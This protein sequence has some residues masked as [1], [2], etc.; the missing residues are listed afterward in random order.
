M[1]HDPMDHHAFL[2]YLLRM[3]LYLLR[4]SLAYAIL[5]SSIYRI[6]SPSL[7][8]QLAVS[9]Q[10]SLGDSFLQLPLVASSLKFS[11]EALLTFP[12]VSC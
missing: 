6:R 9:F 1:T 12:I 7:A 5:I 3:S 10:S 4:M 8:R 11:P 2:F